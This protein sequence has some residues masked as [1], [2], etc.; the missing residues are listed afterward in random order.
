ML[1]CLSDSSRLVDDACCLRVA[2]INMYNTQHNKRSNVEC[3]WLLVVLINLFS[4]AHYWDFLFAFLLFPAS[5][6]CLREFDSMTPK[7]KSSS[8]KKKTG[9]QE[10]KIHTRLIWGVRDE[11]S[12]AAH[13]ISWLTKK[14]HHRARIGV[15]VVNRRE[16]REHKV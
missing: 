3:C 11:E 6:S 9:A 4:L 1:I 10:M 5:S 14:N 13:T 15:D 16:K 12:S 7:K 2:D 8:N